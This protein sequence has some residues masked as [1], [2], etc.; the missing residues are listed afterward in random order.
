MRGYEAR[1]RAAIGDSW[2]G[3]TP[4]FRLQV[5]ERGRL[6]A[7]LA[8]GKT[9]P[10]YDWASLTKIVFTTSA[11]MR[12]AEEKLLSLREPVARRLSFFAESAAREATIAQ[13]LS[14][15]AGLTWWEPFYERIDLRLPREERWRRMRGLLADAVRRSRPSEPKKAVYSDLDFLSLGFIVEDAFDK[16]LLDVWREMR[17]RFGFRAVDFHVDNRPKRKRSS[18]AP[19]EQGGF[20]ATLS[21]ALQPQWGEG[22][23]VQG[24]VHDENA[25]ALGGVA[26][27][28]GLFGDVDDLAR[29][30]LF[31]R[32]A[33]RGDVQRGLPK[34]ET[35]ARFARRAVP[36]AVGDWALGFMT[37]SKPSSSAG[38][39]FSSR[40]IGHTGFTGTSLWLDPRRDLIVAVLSN[41]VHPTREN[42]AF[43][44]LRGPLH[45]WCV[46]CL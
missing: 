43:V 39:R 14:H 34:P 4:G 8:L 35:V 16:P 28:A 17:G 25:W 42:K 31:L 13:I 23:A 33:L 46:E 40:S 19:T 11:A 30:A 2:K 12:A 9:Y 36:R 27:H 3:A 21:Q 22:G 29:Y 1:L 7:D 41:R 24:E 37:P 44:E 18:Y 38:D 5:L 6:R 10:I 26:P 45:N 15:S 32:R 20:R